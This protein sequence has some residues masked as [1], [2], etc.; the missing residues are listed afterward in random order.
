MPAGA[1]ADPCETSGE[2]P[3]ADVAVAICDKAN[4]GDDVGAPDDLEGCCVAVFRCASDAECGVDEVCVV[5]AG[6][7]DIRVCDPEAQTGCPD[8][9]RCLVDDDGPRCR[10]PPPLASCELV[11]VRLAAFVGDPI[12]VGLVARDAAGR[13]ITTAQ[14]S[15]LTAACPDAACVAP[16]T[17]V[18]PGSGLLCASAPVVVASTTA[19]RAAV[20]VTSPTGPVAGATVRFV[21]DGQGTE[22]ASAAT[23]LASV[24]VDD[25]A[26]LQAV[27]VRIG[28]TG[29]LLGPGPAE[30]PAHPHGE[31]NLPIFVRSPSLLDENKRTSL[32]SMTALS[33]PS[34]W[35]L[36]SRMPSSPSR[37]K[38]TS[39]VSAE[40]PND[41]C[42]PGAAPQL[43]A[44]IVPRWGPSS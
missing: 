18:E 38:L 31:P 23:G 41:L 15:P 20:L 43:E 1:A 44:P 21:V 34:P 2:H 25:G 29:P 39:T 28:R 24:V 4:D 27:T 35:S 8:G 26:I 37:P 5:G 7:C 40:Q 9:L 30:R 42:L 33:M 13:V 22:V 19:G 11:P 3:A 32:D 16:L 6:R 36:T 14:P 17:L 10:P 12:E